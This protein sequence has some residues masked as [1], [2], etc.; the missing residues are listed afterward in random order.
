MVAGEGEGDEEGRKNRNIL[1]ESSDTLGGIVIAVMVGR[2][3]NGG[4]GGMVIS[5]RFRTAGGYRETGYWVDMG[6]G[7][8]DV[9]LS[10]TLHSKKKEKKNKNNL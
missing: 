2:V 1:E 6:R 7:D 4:N 5:R 8:G 3:G 9:M 10:I